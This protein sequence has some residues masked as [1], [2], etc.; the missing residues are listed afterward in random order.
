MVRTMEVQALADS[1][2]GDEAKAE[3]WLHTP[4]GALSGQV[5]ADLLKDELGAAVVREA[6]EQIAHGIFA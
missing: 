1:I 3:L 2:F 5:P 4:N 6:L